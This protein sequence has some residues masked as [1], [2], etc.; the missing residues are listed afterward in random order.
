MIGRIS[1]VE[2]EYEE[3]TEEYI[4]LNSFGLKLVS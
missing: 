2:T 3:E 1:D 4:L